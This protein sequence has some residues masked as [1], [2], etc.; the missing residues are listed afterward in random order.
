[1]RW[2]V[3][4]ILIALPTILYFAYAFSIRAKAEREGREVYDPLDRPPVFWLL[5]AGV[6][7]CGIVLAIWG[8]SGGAPPGSTYTPPRMEDGQIVPGGFS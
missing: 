6:V 2:L 5:L 3:P 8:L 4:V 7:L 1:L